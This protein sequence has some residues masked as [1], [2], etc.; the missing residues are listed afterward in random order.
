MRTPR[1]RRT[2]RS[3][4]LAGLLTVA[5][6]TSL[7]AVAPAP[8]AAAQEPFPAYAVFNVPSE[9][10]VRD[11]T[12]EQE[13]VALA[14]AV[15]SGSWIRGVMFSWTSTPVAEALARAA[16]RGAVVRVVV[17]SRGHGGVNARPNNAAINTLK[18]AD[19]D[20]LVFCGTSSATVPGSTACIGNHSKSIQHNKFFTFSTSG[21]TKRTVLVTSQNLTYSQNNRFNNAVVIQEDYDLY[22]Q[23]VRYFNDLRAERKNT[24]YYGSGNGYYRSPNTSVTTY[25][26]PRASGDTLVKILEFLT[27]SESGCSV[28]LAQL[29]FTNPRRPVAQELLRIARLGC[30]VRIVYSTMGADIHRILRQSGNISLKKYYDAGSGNY[31]GR[32]VDVH[33][34]YMII[35]GNYNDT[36]GRTIV[37]TGSHNLTGPALRNHDETL[38]KIEHP[39]VSADYRDNFA[40]LWSRAICVNPDNGSCT[41]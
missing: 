40:T 37:Y 27:R 39:T 13:I 16:D 14:D 25:H 15:P 4:A 3:R 26:S 21:D 18:A 38:L 23:F 11:R 12:I 24:N 2:S 19:L 5:L 28:E 10:A 41:Y 32:V 33:S 30:Q 7:A 22:N 20:D 31:D 34:K 17:D 9:T 35:N 1:H 36:S 8:P 29:Y 6:A